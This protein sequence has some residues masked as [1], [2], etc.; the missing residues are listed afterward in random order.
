[1][2]ECLA[3]VN[4]N[5][6]NRARFYKSRRAGRS[7]GFPELAS[8]PF[9]LQ[10][11]GIQRRKSRRRDTFKVVSLASGHKPHGQGSA[12][13]VIGSFANRGGGHDAKAIAPAF[14]SRRP[15][16][17]ALACPTSGSECWHR[18]CAEEVFLHRCPDG[19]QELRRARIGVPSPAVFLSVHV[20]NASIKCGRVRPFEGPVGLSGRQEATRGS[21]LLGTRALLRNQ[22]PSD[23]LVPN[24]KKAR[25]PEP[26]GVARVYFNASRVRLFKQSTKRC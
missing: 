20:P 5:P 19:D 17:G 16:N 10:G 14:V 15:R 8:R 9:P 26:A 23:L 24:K 7:G 2:T 22:Q 3:S 4:K 6:A 21:A 12:L 1:M 11:Q 18:Y 13:P 25:R